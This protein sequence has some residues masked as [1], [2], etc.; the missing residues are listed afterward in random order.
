MPLRSPDPAGSTRG[1]AAF[2]PEDASIGRIAAVGIGLIVGI[3]ILLAFVTI[4]FLGFVRRPL[5]L[6]IPSPGLAVG[7]SPG[8]PL[9]PGPVLEAEPGVSAASV[10]SQ[11]ELAL[12]SYGWVDQKNGVVRIPIE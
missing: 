7:Q 12:H 8:Q 2:E 3:L 10:R 5:A 1:P 9:P 4:L 11:E 6:Q